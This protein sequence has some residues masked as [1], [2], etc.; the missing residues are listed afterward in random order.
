MFRLNL[1]RQNA[2]AAESGKPKLKPNV[3]KEW[4]DKYRMAIAA[5]IDEESKRLVREPP[6]SC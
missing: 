6:S 2:K 1:Y 4:I 3:N 5:L